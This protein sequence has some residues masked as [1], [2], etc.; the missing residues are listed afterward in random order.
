MK[1]LI[2]YSLVYGTFIL[3]LAA[4]SGLVAGAHSLAC[5]QRWAG[6]GMESSWGLL[7]GCRVKM[8]DGRTLPEERVREFVGV[9]PSSA[10]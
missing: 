4:L 5:A 3:V 8:R 6:S 1:K 7:S 10:R 2:A 9:D